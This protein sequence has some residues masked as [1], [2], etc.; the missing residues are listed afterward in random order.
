VLRHIS[1]TGTRVSE[2]ARRCGYAKQRIAYVVDD[3]AR[4]GY[5]SIVPD[6]A[7][8]RATL[9]RLTA[10][11]DALIESPLF[12]SK[13]AERSLEQK[14]GSSTVAALRA[15]LTAAVE[16]GSGSQAAAEADLSRR[17]RR[18]RGRARHEAFQGRRRQLSNR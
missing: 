12:H 10:R 3:L 8:G 16:A 17:G 13:A 4:L 1:A 6:P 18:R 2:V 14:I 9:V 11:G 5:V 7:D 15:G